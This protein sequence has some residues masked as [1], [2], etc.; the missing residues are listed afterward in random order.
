MP[1]FL[2]G[3]CRRQGL[4]TVPFAPDN[5]N[6]REVG[7]TVALSPRF[8]GRGSTTAAPTGCIGSARDNPGVRWVLADDLAAAVTGPQPQPPEPVQ[9]ARVLASIHSHATVLPMRFGTGVA[10]DEAAIAM[11]R[12]YSQQW[13]RCLDRLDGASE[14]GL[15]ISLARG[16]APPEPAA[17]TAA[18]A[19]LAG[20][21]ARYAWE[22]RL[23]GQTAAVAE[24]CVERLRRWC[25]EWRQ[26]APAIPGLVRMAFLVDRDRAAAFRQ[27]AAAV[28]ARHA[29]GSCVVLGPWPPYSFLQAP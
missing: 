23:R 16:E 12:S 9:H 20:R 25:R 3:I 13:L 29:D 14:M 4:P 2:L 11:L 18:S 15:R 27:H 19:Y 8:P 5:D 26:L 28:L 24:R 1:L 7:A 17:A 22:D 6:D 21:R 10:D